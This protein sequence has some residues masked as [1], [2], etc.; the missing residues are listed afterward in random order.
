[1]RDQEN[2]L[3]LYDVTLIFAVAAAAWALVFYSGLFN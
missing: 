1:M 3:Q 2:K